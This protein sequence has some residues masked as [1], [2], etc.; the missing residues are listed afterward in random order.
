MTDAV[1]RN[2]RPDVR[3]WRVYNNGHIKNETHVLWPHAEGAGYNGNVSAWSEH[4]KK[5]RSGCAQIVQEGDQ[6][7][8]VIY[9]GYLDEKR[10]ADIIQAGL[11]DMRLGGGE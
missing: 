3:I 5:W 11:P 6:T 9:N 4:N 8:R 10:L 7:P 1:S 2:E